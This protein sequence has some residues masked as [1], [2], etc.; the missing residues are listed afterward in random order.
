MDFNVKASEI[1]DNIA[2]T[3]KVSEILAEIIKE[4]QTL[5]TQ[6]SGLADANVVLSDENGKLRK[7]NSEYLLNMGV[8]V[9]SEKETAPQKE[10]KP[11]ETIAIESFI[12]DGKII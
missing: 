11:I 2:D 7:L 12:K 9:N 4:G 3:A 8:K 6:N 10:E 5:Q 1:I